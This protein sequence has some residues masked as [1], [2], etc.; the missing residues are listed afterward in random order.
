VVLCYTPTHTHARTHAHLCTHT[1][2]LRGSMDSSGKVSTVLCYENN[3][4]SCV[5]RRYQPGTGRVLVVDG[6]GSMQWSYTEMDINR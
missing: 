4:R 6:G 1:Q 5:K 3:Q 2:G